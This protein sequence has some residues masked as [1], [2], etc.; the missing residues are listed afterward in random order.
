[1]SNPVIV[2]FAPS[3]TGYL[4]VGNVRTAIVNWLF[5]RKQGGKFILRI[6]DTDLER[7]R[8]E[9]ATAIQEDLDWLG[10]TQDSSF[11]QSER[12]ARYEAAKQKLIE[13]GRLYPCYETPDELEVK[14]K[15]LASRGLPPIYDRSALKLSDAQKQ[16]YEAQGRQPHWRFKLD[17]A[18]IAWDDMIRG[19]V[20]FKGEHLAD[21][22]LIREDGVPLFTLSTSVDDGDEGI[23]HII[24]GEDHVSNSAIQIQLMQAL[25][26]TP[27]TMGHMALLKMAEGKISKRK[28]GGDLRSLREDGI[29]PLV[30]MSYL[31]R[32]GT[33]DAIE[34]L[35]S[36]EA[37]IDSF[38]IGKFGRAMANYDPQEMERLNEKLL[39]QL[40]FAD[41]QNELAKLGIAGIDE[42]FWEQIKPNIARLPE[43]KDWWEMLHTPI[44]PVI[45]DAEFTQAAA[46]CL[47]DGEWSAERWG[48]FVEA[49]KGKTG[50]K[51]KQLFMPL[52]LALTGRE[53]GPELPTLFALL[54]RERT[55][56][57][58]KGEAA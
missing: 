16:E 13:A 31:A 11:R 54:G 26:Y 4:H 37:I 18:P 44:T 35:D 36:N 27:P 47:P 39:H 56:K 10:L 12:F 3:P 20:E 17:H 42:D 57:R 58:L 9:F 38:D 15:M 24:R 19:P 28:G 34:L 23:T 51:G 7:S 6:D 33:S 30:V 40:P 49:V 52:R 43:V 2:R 25:G 46:E 21:P 55:E 29:F 48:E 50:R 14:R 41:V 53:D 8:E 5:A 1:M 45:E 32:I 22:V